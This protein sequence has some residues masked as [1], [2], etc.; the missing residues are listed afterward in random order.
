MFF[1]IGKRPKGKNKLQ[2]IKLKGNISMIVVQP[3][4][5]TTR[6][7][8]RQAERAIDDALYTSIRRTAILFLPIEWEIT[9]I[10]GESGKNVKKQDSIL[11]Q[12]RP[13]P[14]DTSKIW[15]GKDQMVK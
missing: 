13:I 8:I 7:A 3:S 15:Q 9:I 14:V 10:E 5:T 2:K 12:L 4:K 1:S 11:Q 6:E